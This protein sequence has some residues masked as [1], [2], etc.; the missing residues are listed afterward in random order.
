MIGVFVEAATNAVIRRERAKIEKQLGRR[1]E[2]KEWI[3][4]MIH[5]NL[6]TDP[7]KKQENNY[8]RTNLRLG[9]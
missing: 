4:Y 1:V 5:C 7:N 3:D 2:D 8:G 9:R 6:L